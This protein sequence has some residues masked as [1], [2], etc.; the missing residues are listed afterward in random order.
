MAYRS[1]V[2]IQADIDDV[3]ENLRKAR[4]AT[5]YGF[6]GRNLTRSYDGLRSE[7]RELREELRAS[8]AAAAGGSSIVTIT[9]YRRF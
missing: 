6:G 9:T 8:E 2:D 5:S 1:T 4:A 3:R 7:L